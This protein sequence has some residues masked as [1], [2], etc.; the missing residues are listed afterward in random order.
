[1]EKIYHDNANQKKVGLGDLLCLGGSVTVVALVYGCGAGSIP[2]PGT[3]ICHEHGKKKKKKSW[4]GIINTR[5]N[6]LRAK[7]IE[8][9]C[10]FIIKKG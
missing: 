2:S 8:I 10:Y 7:M 5:Q 3:S 6:P 9:K 4:T 1:M